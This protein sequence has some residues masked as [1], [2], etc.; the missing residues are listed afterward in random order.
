[1]NAINA[2][3]DSLIDYAGMYPPSSLSLQTATQ[4]YLGYRRSKHNWALGRFI[5]DWSRMTD[6]RKAVRDSRS[7]LK[8]SLIATAAADW[9]SIARQSD[10]GLSVDTIE[11]KCD[12]PS[13]IERICK[14]VPSSV[15][16]YFEV[17]IESGNSEIL[18]AISDTGSRAKLRMGG[19]IP[20]ALPS[21]LGI[22]NMLKAL[23]DRR[24]PFKATAGLH[25]PIRSHHRLTYE[26]GSPTGKMHGFL[27]LACASA[28][29]YSGGEAS[30]AQCLLEEED[31]RAWSL[32]DGSI[33]WRT[34]DLSAELLESVR[35]RFF[36][37]FGSCSFEEPIGDLE[38]L[39]WL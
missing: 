3:L 39:G 1:M 14:Q 32:N 2:L 26:A 29:V 6:L 27:N 35:E 36:I 12:R 38:A 4:N 30:Y 33:R 16:M 22:A 5:V 25:H 11:I 17:P 13:E 31:P 18:D 8:L 10:E 23:A 34:L 19:L 7:G 28:L 37:S 21:T 20:E 9:D 15:T 24:I